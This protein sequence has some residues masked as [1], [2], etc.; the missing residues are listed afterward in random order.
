MTRPP[1]ALYRE[2][3]NFAWWLYAALACILALLV[4]GYQMKSQTAPLPESHK[5]MGGLEAPVFLLL[6]VCL[7][8]LLVFGVLHMTTQVTPDACHIW[9][10]WIPTV[11][12]SI[13]VVSIKQVEIVRYNALRDHGFWGVRTTKDGE[14]VYTAS[15]DRAVRLHL[16]DGTRVLIGSQRPEELASVLES[17]RR[18][19]A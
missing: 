11:R 3:Q 16:A 9:F 1:S 4:L 14:R 6:G 15:G 2:E 8:S 12:R 13:P 5:G 7:P 19:V 10:G 18:L 17:E